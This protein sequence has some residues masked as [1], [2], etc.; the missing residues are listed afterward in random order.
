M[1][2]CICA[3]VCSCMQKPE[4]NAECLAPSLSRFFFLR[5]GLSLNLYSLPNLIKV[6][7]YELPGVHLFLHSPILQTQSCTYRRPC[8]AV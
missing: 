7:N 5:Q 3:Y 6:A 1:Q 4:V 2:M 8:P